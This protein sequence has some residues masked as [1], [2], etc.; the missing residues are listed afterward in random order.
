MWTEEN[1]IGIKN[2]IFDFV[3]CEDK[4]YACDCDQITVFDM[5]GKILRHIPVMSPINVTT[6]DDNIIVRTE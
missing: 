2:D 1:Y 6:M 5:T 3:I 4:I